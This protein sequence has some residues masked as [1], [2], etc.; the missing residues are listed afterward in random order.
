MKYVFVESVHTAYRTLNLYVIV[1]TLSQH[2]TVTL[3]NLLA[4]E[5]Y[6]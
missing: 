6:I 3:L 2:S 5:F 1:I 4:P